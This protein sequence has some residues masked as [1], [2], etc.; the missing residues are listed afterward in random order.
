MSG[1]HT[2]TVHTHTQL[3]IY[4]IDAWNIYL[5]TYIHIHWI[6]IELHISH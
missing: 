2:Y 6:K 5:R 4:T 1:I 3:H